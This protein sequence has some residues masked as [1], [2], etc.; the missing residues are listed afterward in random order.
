LLVV[1]FIVMEWRWREQ[2]FALETIGISWKRPLRWVFYSAL[3]CL[4]LMYMHTEET[5]FIYFQ[6]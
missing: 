1:F 5:P 3:I 4:I 6:F 2:Q